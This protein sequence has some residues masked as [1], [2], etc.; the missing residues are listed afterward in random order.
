[1]KSLTNVP[2]SKHAEPLHRHGADVRDP[3][4]RTGDYPL[5]RK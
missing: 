4:C 3:G 5:H 2:V 1:M